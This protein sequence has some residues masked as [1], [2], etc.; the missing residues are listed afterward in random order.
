MIMN[1]LRLLSRNV[2][3]IARSTAQVRH[4]QSTSLLLTGKVH[5]ATD[6]NFQELITAKEPVLVDFH[7]EWCRPCHT[8]DPIL[9]DA[10]KKS[11]TVTL[12]RVN[13]DDCPETSTQFQIASIPCVMVFKNGQPVDKFV[14]AYP[15]DVV[16]SFVQKHA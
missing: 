4:F 15:K 12:V 8:L 9:R 2:Q 5:D 16:N 6:K 1:S 10:V 3:Q 13:V 11:G 14:G 7:A